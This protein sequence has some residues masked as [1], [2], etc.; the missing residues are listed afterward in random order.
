MLRAATSA[1]ERSHNVT[2]TV[3]DRATTP[4]R[5]G[6][7]ARAVRPAG[8]VHTVSTA[9]V[10]TTALRHYRRPSWWPA[11]APRPATGTAG[12]G[13]ADERATVDPATGS[14]GSRP[15]TRPAGSRAAADGTTTAGSAG[16][17]PA[18]HSHTAT[19][20]DDAAVGSATDATGD[21]AAFRTAVAGPA[22][23]GAAAFRT[24]ASG[25]AAGTATDRPPAAGRT[26]A[27]ACGAGGRATGHG[28]DAGTTAAD[29]RE[30]AISR[31]GCD[32]CGRADESPSHDASLDTAG[33]RVGGARTARRH[34]RRGG[35]TGLQSIARNHAASTNS[36]LTQP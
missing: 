24:A 25:T 13:P 15:A 23:D 14:A 19:D 7:C 6:D 20:G 17:C 36:V 26:A 34:A 21:P 4:T 3:F 16:L 22:V 10:H 8:T 9:T 18:A 2:A 1:T 33:W 30:T 28:S 29:G 11:P 12:P 27:Q 35:R 32:R 31:W 5:T